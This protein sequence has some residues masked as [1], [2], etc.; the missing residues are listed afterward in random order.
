MDILDV[1]NFRILTE[2]GKK[3]NKAMMSGL[4]SQNCRNYELNNIIMHVIEEL[5]IMA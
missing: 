2:I 4:C 5:Y 1:I 3:K